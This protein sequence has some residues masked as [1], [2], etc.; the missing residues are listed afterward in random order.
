MNKNLLYIFISLTIS[1]NIFIFIQAIVVT[2]TGVKQGQNVHSNII[3][4]LLYATL[5]RFFNRVPLGRIVS[6][7]SK[8]LKEMDEVISNTFCSAITTACKILSSLIICIYTSTPYTL[9]PVAVVTV[10]FIKLR[11]FYISSQN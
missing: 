1:A 7:L 10:I 2:Y 9:I 8:D 5:N 4:G 3:K 11:N 6:R